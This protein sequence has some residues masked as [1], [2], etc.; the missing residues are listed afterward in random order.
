MIKSES[1][2]QTVSAEK[3][4]YFYNEIGKY[5]GKSA[6]S[7]KDFGEKIMELDEK[8]LRFHLQRGD[9]EKWIGGVLKD[10]ELARQM[11]ELRETF[12]PSDNLRDRLHS[13]VSK[14]L[15]KL[16]NTHPAQQISSPKMQTGRK[17]DDMRKR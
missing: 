15:E 10:E 5:A 6:V 14:R 7:L 13:M 3:A 8:S 16:S 4:F 11:K 17:R 2:P 9:F 12:V 1:V